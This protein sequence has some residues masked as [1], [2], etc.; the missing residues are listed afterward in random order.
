MAG[1]AEAS[2]LRSH[3]PDRFEPAFAAVAQAPMGREALFLSHFW[4]PVA[5]GTSFARSSPEHA[6]RLRDREAIMSRSSDLFSHRA[7]RILAG[8]GVLALALLVAASPAAAH[9]K[10]KKH[11][12]GHGKKHSPYVGVYSPYH[13]TSHHGR[14]YGRK[15]GHDRFVVPRAIHRHHVGKYER[16][17]HGRSYYRPHRHHHTVYAFP[18]F[19]DM[20]GY[21]YPDPAYVPYAYC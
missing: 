8:A 7:V 20:Y 18:V 1:Q 14:H 21:P 6:E 12:K 19:Y 5:A 2:A 13:G 11:G 17:Y 10:Y 9:D 3:A 15:H 16:Y 4:Q